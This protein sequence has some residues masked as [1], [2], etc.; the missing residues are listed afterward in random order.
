MASIFVDFEDLPGP[1]RDAGGKFRPKRLIEANNGPVASYFG[2]TSYG[3]SSLVVK[4]SGITDVLR[5]LTLL[6]F[7]G[8]TPC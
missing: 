6:R 5:S 4:G 7:P 3:N 1:P 8:K 2:A